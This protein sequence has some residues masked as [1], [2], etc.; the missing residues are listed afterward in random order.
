MHLHLLENRDSFGWATFGGYWPQG[1]V[2]ENRFQLTN[3][4]GEVIDVQSDITARW[5]DGSVRWS[6][7]V[8]RAESLGEKGELKAVPGPFSGKGAAYP[9]SSGLTVDE[10]EDRWV[11]AGSRFSMT[12]PKEGAVLA[13]EAVLDSTPMFR[14]IEPVLSL[15]HESGTSGRML[16]ETV[17]CGASVRQRQAEET[18]PL[19]VTFRFDGVFLE[20]S[21]ELKIC[22][23]AS[24][25][26]TR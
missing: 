21:L 15:A 13:A 16:R 10:R 12:V 7:H 19:Q 14:G 6:R 9:E 5:A 20:D 11:V 22:T 4:R 26:R 18:G 2:R 23:P 17:A 24:P 3:E 8:V 1:A 25:L